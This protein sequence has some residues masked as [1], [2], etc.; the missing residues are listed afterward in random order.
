M[1]KE[2]YVYLYPENMEAAEP[3]NCHVIE[4]KYDE[5]NNRLTFPPDRICLDGQYKK[6]VNT[7]IKRGQI[8]PHDDDYMRIFLAERQNAGDQVCANCVRYFYA[9]PRNA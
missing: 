6:K 5:E 8:Q 1:L 7:T 2:V 4:A 9:D 3:V